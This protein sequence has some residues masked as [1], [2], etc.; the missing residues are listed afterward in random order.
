[1]KKIIY[2]VIG[3]VLYQIGIEMGYPK[4]A[5]D[6]KKWAHKNVK[7]ECVSNIFKSVGCSVYDAV[8]MLADIFRSI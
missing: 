5:A 1:M 7:S 3:I 4:F 8:K 6:S 2:L